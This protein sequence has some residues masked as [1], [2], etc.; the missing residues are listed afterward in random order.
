[1]T[2]TLMLAGSPIIL[3]RGENPTNEGVYLKFA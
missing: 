2:V 3:S 1:M